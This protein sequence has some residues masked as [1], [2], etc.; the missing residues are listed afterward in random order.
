MPALNPLTGKAA[1]AVTIPPWATIIAYDGAVRSGKTVGELLYWV[2][3]CL[4]GPQG[5]LL[6]GGRTERTIANNLIR[7]LQTWFGTKSIIYRQ[8]T[9]VCTI[10]GRECLVVGFNDSQAQTK[11]QGLTLAG[12]LLDEAATIPESAFTMLVSRLSVPGARLFLTCNPE[13]PEHWLKRKWLD[14]ARLWIDKNGVTHQQDDKNTLNLYRVTFILDDNTWLVNN[15]P[16]YIRE[17]KRQY[18]GLYYRR[19]IESEWVA[20]EGAVYPMWDP[21]KH[22][23]DWTQLPHMSRILGVGC[24]YGTT[25]ASTGIMLGLHELKDQY[26]RITGHDLY[27]LDEFRYDS[28]A[29]NPRITDSDLSQRFRRWLSKPHL[30]YETA[31]QPEWVFVDPAAASYKVQLAQDGIRN[32]A[33]GENNVSYGISRVATLLDTGKL[34]VSDKCKGLIEEFPGYSWDPKASDNGLDKPIKQADHSLDGLRYVVATTETEWQPLLTTT[35][36]QPW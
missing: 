34:H 25:N 28:R 27:V 4:H 5:L 36:G 14:R 11:I 23:V 20:A 6:I 8:S 12:A 32:L 18:T 24:D 33:D 3:Y 1:T 26:G 16:Q 15:N 22:V 29:G 31:L 2:K 19:M 35:G 30:P 10:F 7:P 21:D 13:G 9:G 17:L